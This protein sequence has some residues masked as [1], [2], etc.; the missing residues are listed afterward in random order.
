MLSRYHEEHDSDEP[1]HGDQVGEHAD[2]R[3]PTYWPLRP[4]ELQRP[5]EAAEYSEQQKAPGPAAET[6]G[7]GVVCEE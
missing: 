5:S 3:D 4:D 6:D 7:G 1:A 2:L